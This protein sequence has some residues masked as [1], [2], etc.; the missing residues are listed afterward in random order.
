MTERVTDVGRPTNDADLWRVTPWRTGRS[1][2]RT[3]Y[4]VVGTEVS[5]DDQIL[6][7]VDTRA[8]AEHII[9]VHNA[10]LETP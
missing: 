4:M 2:G 7:M 9:A 6:G 1:L 5:K 10:T 3:L 8:L